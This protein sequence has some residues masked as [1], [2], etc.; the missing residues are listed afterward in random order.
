[1]VEE[2]VKNMKKAVFFDVDGTIIDTFNGKHEISSAV[3]K[4]ICDLQAAGH[5][6]FVATGRPYAFI[7]P[8]LWNF[9]FDGFVLSNGAQVIMNNQSVFDDTMDKDFIK[10]FTEE[11]DKEG[12]AYVLEGGHH[13]YISPHGEA[14]YNFC[15]NLGISK[16]MLKREYNVDEIDVYKIELLC[17]DKKTEECCTNL[18]KKYPEY[19]CYYSISNVLF[20]VYAKKNNKA[21][22]IERT[23]EFLN[24]PI[25]NSYAFG[26]GLNDVEMLESVGCGIA[27]GN[28][29]DEVKRC[30]KKVTDT[31][32]NDGVALAINQI[33]LIDDQKE[34]YKKEA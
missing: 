3:T 22:G 10:H 18:V 7:S 2:G 32:S 11:L 21:K 29:S 31:V 17:K 34:E 26:D 20:E 5:Y 1:M 9:G 15:I 8:I 16:Q 30:A 19:G 12:V 27:M 33:I 13:S 4:A 25:E 6:V 14:M 24:I 23:L 28:A